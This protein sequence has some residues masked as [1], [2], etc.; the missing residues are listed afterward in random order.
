MR[1]RCTD[2]LPTDATLHDVNAALL[3]W[4]DE[5]YHR[6]PHA[7][8]LG[9]TL[10]DLGRHQEA[11]EVWRDLD[12]EMEG[13]EEALQNIAGLSLALNHPSEALAALRRLRDIEDD[14]EAILR[15]DE[16]IRKLEAGG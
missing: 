12:K 14:P 16:T 2:H 7:G 5:D 11:I 13:D 3:A 15:I 1:Q 6:R 4:L 8:L 9:Q 10:N